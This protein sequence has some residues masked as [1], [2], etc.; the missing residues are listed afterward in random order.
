MEPLRTFFIPSQ[1]TDCTADRELA[2]MMI[3]T[4]RT[5]GAFQVFADE[6][7]VNAQHRA[8]TASERFFRQPLDIRRR[9]VSELSF[10]GFVAEG[11]SCSGQHAD[12]TEAF[13]SCKDI[14]LHDTRVLARWPGHGPVPW[15]DAEFRDSLQAFSVLL[16]RL[17]D[18]LLKLTALGLGVP[19]RLFTAGTQDGFHTLRAH[20]FAAA[21]ATRQRGLGAHT[22]PGWL[23]IEVQDG[24][25]GLHIRPPVIGET[26]RRNWVPGESTRGVHEN[27]AP[28]MALGAM[29]RTLTVQ[30]GDMLQF[31]T[32]GRL[33]ATPSKAMLGSRER[34]AMS[35]SYAPNFNA[36]LEPMEEGMSSGER[37]HYG[38]HA[39]R[40]LVRS[41]PQQMAARMLKEDVRWT[42]LTALRDMAFHRASERALERA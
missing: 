21:S 40:E 15:P 2:H 9:H 11:D 31:V 6:A 12:A 29:P 28:W 30:P 23:A 26:R 41:Y 4:W 37:V 25:G 5:D 3:R 14:A 20:R 7:V 27:D 18:S 16:A 24:V 8:F 36:V 38:T 19:K 42:A 34:V 13:V 32:S 33:L 35:Y 22:D 10:S 1:V 39:V 17:G